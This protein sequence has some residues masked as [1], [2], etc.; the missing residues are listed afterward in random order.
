MGPHEKKKKHRRW[1][2]G[3]E[4]N[5]TSNR[6]KQKVSKNPLP[7]YSTSLDF[8][9]C[10]CG[11]LTPR[12]ARAITTAST[13]QSIKAQHQLSQRS[14]KSSS[15][16]QEHVHANHIKKI[17]IPPRPQF[18]SCILRRGAVSPELQFLCAL[19]SRPTSWQHSSEPGIPK[20][21]RR[22]PPHLSLRRLLLP[23][24]G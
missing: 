13:I 8:R 16:F 18:R 2:E 17:T 7:V 6:Y 21:D 15:S 22:K 19:L 9:Q 1:V 24:L 11:T 12:N 20:R 23:G 10:A 5:T 14:A 3:R 4:I